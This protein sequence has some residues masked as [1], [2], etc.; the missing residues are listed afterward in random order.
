MKNILFISPTGTLD[1]GAEI[2]ITNLMGFLIEEKRY[3]IFNIYP[4]SPHPSQVNYVEKLKDFG[5]QNIPLA[6][7]EWW[8]MEAPEPS[9][10]E[11]STKLAFYRE[12]LYQIRKVIRESDIDLVITNTVNTFYG[13]IAAA[14][15]GVAHY[16]LIHEFPNAEFEYYKDKLPFIIEN[17]DKVFAVRGNLANELNRLTST[18]SSCKMGTFI[19]YS[20]IKNHQ[21]FLDEQGD[22]IRLISVGKIN[23]N[24]NQLEI[25]KAYSQLGI[26]NPLIFIGGWDDEYKKQCD[27][28]IKEHRLKSVVFMGHKDNPW[29]HISEKDIAI[30]SSKMETFGLVY[31]EAILN[32]IPTIVSDNPGFLT[33]H[34]FFNVGRLYPLGNLDR[35]VSTIQQMIAN[36]DIEKYELIKRKSELANQFTL[37]TCFKEVIESIDQ[38][39]MPSP[40]SIRAL[41]SLFGRFKEDLDILQLMNQEVRIFYQ[42][43]NEGF[44]I[45][46]SM[47][48][49]LKNKDILEFQI[50][51]GV[52]VLRIDLGEVPMIFQNVCLSSFN[53]K[54]EI[55]PH[56]SNGLRYTNG[57]IFGNS[58]PQL[59]YNI[60][61]F[62]E[63]FV[64][65]YEKLNMIE[66]TGIS[67]HQELTQKFVDL[68]AK[69][70]DLSDEIK[71]VSNQY[72][73][74]IGS[75]RWT[76]PTKIINIIRRK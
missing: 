27:R 40:K 68:E 48:F 64:L 58:D 59:I 46:N 55:L 21:D 66:D 6:T 28:F 45:N 34:D 44:S 56:S 2:S 51:Q 14:C 75:K 76:I 42:Y 20:E 32:G 35:L 36:F 9:D 62:G 15:E 11:E 41:E 8:W 31:V 5:V 24:K 37:R 60:A 17:S 39:A 72:R 26:S 65:S 74:V 18:F 13:A 53:F 22:E 70:K 4:V 43:E 71:V 54:T 63:K 67:F 69:N 25:I 73:A 7:P 3:N 30:F 1:N 49:C 12:N 52:K 19:P 23:E 50:P 10:F 38:M 16:W 57:V 33:V 47:A 29:E 61:H